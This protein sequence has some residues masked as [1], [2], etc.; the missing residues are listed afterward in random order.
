ML[1]HRPQ[2]AA[3][4]LV[5]LSRTYLN[6]DGDTERDP[7]SELVITIDSAVLT[8]AAGR[9]TYRNGGA[10][11]SADARRVACDTKLVVVLAENSGVLDVSAASRT[12]PAPLRRA[13]LARDNGC[14]T[15]PGCNETR[16]SRLHAHHVWHWADGGPT[17]LD[18]LT[19]LCRTHHR[20]IHHDGYTITASNGTF[21]FADPD[22]QQIPPVN[23]EHSPPAVLS[24]IDPASIPSWDGTPFSLEYVVS[25]LLHR[26]AWRRNQQSCLEH[27]KITH[28]LAA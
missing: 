25:V 7:D 11:S 27:A 19:M 3:D 21:T 18:N 23:T 17:V 9:A 15:M 28:D 16:Q 26:R 6:G 5:A 22:G 1:E 10:L 14:C 24:N 13:L 2:T 12:I 4:A 20:A 8:E